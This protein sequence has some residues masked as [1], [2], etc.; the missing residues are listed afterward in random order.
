MTLNTL[1]KNRNL[2]SRI[3]KIG[4]KLLS[5]KKLEVYYTSLLEIL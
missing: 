4:V 3:L 2:M 5:T 1:Y